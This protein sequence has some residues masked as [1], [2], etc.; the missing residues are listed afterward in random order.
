MQRLLHGTVTSGFSSRQE[1]S[2][3]IVLFSDDVLFEKEGLKGGNAIALGLGLGDRTSL[4]LDFSIENDFENIEDVRRRTSE[5]L[6]RRFGSAGYL[7]LDFK[8]EPK[9]K[10]L[11][12]VA[13]HAGAGTWSHSN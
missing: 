6:L 10:E 8:F 2:A 4:D 13:A 1:S 12:E 9:P 5:A 11:R 7:V 3:V